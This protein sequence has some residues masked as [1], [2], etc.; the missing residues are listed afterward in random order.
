MRILI[1][2]DDDVLAQTL[3][4]HLL[5]QHYVI[6]VAEDGLA[7]W[8]YIQSI[9]YDL[10]LLD[11]DLPHLNGIELCKR[12]R[13]HQHKEPVLLLTAR[14]KIE[15]KVQGL[16]AG[17]DDYLAKPYSLDELLARMRAL[18]RRQDSGSGHPLIRWGPLCLDPKLCKLMVDEQSLALSPKE[19]QLMELFLRHPQQVLNSDQILD[20]I[21][22]FDDIPGKDTV[23]THVRRLR[24]KLKPVGADHWIETVYGLGY[25]LKALSEDQQKHKKD[26]QEIRPGSPEPIREDRI[27]A[28]PPLSTL[29]QTGTSCSTNA[30]VDLG[31]GRDS[32]HSERARQMSQSLWP[33]FRP[34]AIDRLLIIETAIA[35]FEQHSLD[36]EILRQKGERAAHKLIGTLGMFGMSEGS[37]LAQ[38][39]EELLQQNCTAPSQNSILQDSLIVQLNHR[40]QSLRQILGVGTAPIL[41][42]NIVPDLPSYEQALRDIKNYFCIARRHRHV[43]T[44][45][46]IQL[47][48]P[49]YSN[50]TS[51]FS[52]L[53]G[54][55]QL[56]EA[57]VSLVRIKQ[58]MQYWAFS[59]QTALRAEDIVTQCAEHTMLVALFECN[60]DNAISRLQPFV[61]QLSNQLVSGLRQETEGGSDH[62]LKEQPWIAQPSIRL[63]TFPQDGQTLEV[64][65]QLAF[66]SDPDVGN[67]LKDA[68][69]S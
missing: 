28:T 42:Q 19:Y 63:A 25:R 21:W 67:I 35:A 20:R 31:R 4:Q 53:D 37:V 69:V 33:K 66:Q 24:K 52:A 56:Q 68:W 27:I 49:D 26:A 41:S 29:A 39:I 8:E 5:S 48:Y 16:D 55:T 40:C 47:I 6:D 61:Q 54:T 18:L 65:E 58:M 34:K 1:V 32:E 9:T 59:L 57:S 2:E 50:E 44:F 10:I 22:G 15:N 36:S 51:A 12:L 38:Q 45:A 60:K 62:P 14:S 30:T 43:I 17:A 46:W 3:C 13:T 11:I 23:R 7:G 64:L